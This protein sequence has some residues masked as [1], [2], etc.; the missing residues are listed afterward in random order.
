MLKISYNGGRTADDIIKF[1][2]GKANTRGHNKK[3]P[4]TVVDL[5]T[6]NFDSVVMDT[7][8]DVLVEFYAPCELGR[9]GNGIQ[10][11]WIAV[12]RVWPL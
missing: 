9:G 10:R 6:G 1:I 3:A 7:T 8:K 5:D 2:N 4:S 12:C 11:Y